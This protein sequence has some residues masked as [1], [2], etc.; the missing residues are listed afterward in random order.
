MERV[1]TY[2]DCNTWIATVTLSTD[3]YFLE[4]YPY[5][6][7][8]HLLHPVLTKQEKQRMKKEMRGIEQEEMKEGRTDEVS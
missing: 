4:F 3:N 5:Q 8:Y 2:M 7:E 1:T 6:Q